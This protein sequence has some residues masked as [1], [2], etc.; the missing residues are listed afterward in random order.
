MNYVV[1][2]AGLLLGL[3][4]LFMSA[5]GGVFLLA[6]AR[7]FW[8]VAAPCAALGIACTVAGGLMIRSQWKR[9]AG[10]QPPHGRQE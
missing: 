9:R 4:G 10:G 7:G 2:I 6:D 3:V 1:A 8:T 5:C